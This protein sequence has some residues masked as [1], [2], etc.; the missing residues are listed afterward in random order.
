[1][2]T[3]KNVKTV[4][5]AAAPAAAPEAPIPMLEIND[6][7]F[8][9]ADLPPE[10]KEL[11]VIHNEWSTAKQVA[12]DAML[13]AEAGLVPLRRE[14]FKYDAALKSLGVEIATRVGA[15]PKPVE[16]AVNSETLPTA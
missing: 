7:K 16:P 4:P 2:A 12:I 1:M 10:V 15:E 5:E 13:A 14:V 8:V 9:I 6:Q 3:K 11:L